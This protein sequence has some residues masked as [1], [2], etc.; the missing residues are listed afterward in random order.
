MQRAVGKIVIALSQSQRPPPHRWEQ[1]CWFRLTIEYGP[2][3]IQREP[4]T[5]EPQHALSSAG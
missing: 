5:L 1:Y 3:P 2:G 4:K